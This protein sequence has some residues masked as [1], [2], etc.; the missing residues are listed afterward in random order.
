[1]PFSDE[2]IGGAVHAFW[3]ARRAG[4]QSALHDKPFLQL[5]ADELDRLGWPAHV[6]RY[7]GDPEALVAGHFRVAKSWDIVCRDPNLQPRICVEFKSQVGSYGNNENNRY[8]EALGSGLDVRA[9]RGGGTA[10]GFVLVICDDPRREGS[11][12]I[13]FP[14]STL[15]SPKRRISTDARYSLNGSSNLQRVAIHSMM[16]PRSC[17]YGVT[18]PSNTPTAPHCGS[19]TFRIS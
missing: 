4:T 18:A 3:E 14:T 19:S 11:L 8:E 7:A 17:S 12:V 9:K 1:M 6:A 13:V 5:I 2:E 15:G 16:R 10:L